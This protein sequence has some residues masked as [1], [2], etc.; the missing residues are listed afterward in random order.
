MNIVRA[1]A[2]ALRMWALHDERIAHNAEQVTIVGRETML[3]PHGADRGRHRPLAAP[4]FLTQLQSGALRTC[5]QGGVPRRCTALCEWMPSLVWHCQQRF[6]ISYSIRHGDM[7]GARSY[8][9]KLIKSS[10]WTVKKEQHCK[11]TSILKVTTNNF[12]LK[13]RTCMYIR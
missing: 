1:R 4:P 6:F 3:A 10:K 2:H 12:M 11:K 9:E 5:S 7:K 13:T 8:E